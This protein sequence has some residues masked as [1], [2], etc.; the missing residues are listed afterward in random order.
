MKRISDMV[1][2]PAASYTARR[3]LSRARTGN[4]F[5]ARFQAKWIPLGRHPSRPQSRTL[6][7]AIAAQRARELGAARLQCRASG[8]RTSHGSLSAFIMVDQVEDF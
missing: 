3:G 2:K 4:V 6:S 8:V 5:L 7:V 1:Q